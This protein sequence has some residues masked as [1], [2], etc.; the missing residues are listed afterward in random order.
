MAVNVSETMKFKVFCVEEYRMKH[1]M[2]SRET[3]DLFDR[4]GVWKYL[5]DPVLQWQ[6]IGN[7][8][9][10]IEDFIKARS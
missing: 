6:C 4:Y 3:L 7:T 10:D 5:E 1:G 9:L 8:V 2:T